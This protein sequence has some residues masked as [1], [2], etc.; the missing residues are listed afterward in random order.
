MTNKEDKV[1]NIKQDMF[2]DRI[3]REYPEAIQVFISNG[4]EDFADSDLIS[5]LGPFLKLKTALK[6][7]GINI[8]LF[9]QLIEEKLSETRGLNMS[10]VHDLKPGQKAPNLLA[11]LPCPLKIPLQE[12]F[13]SFICSSYRQGE[14]EYLIEGNANNQL[15]YYTYVEQFEDIDDVPDIVISP[16]INS[17]F[18]KGFVEKFIDKGYFAD[19]AEYMPG[20]MLKRAGVKDPGGN[21]TMICM[22]LL[23]MVAD[24]DQMGDLPLP[25]SWGDLLHPQYEKKVVIRGQKEFFCETT[26]LTIFK[27]YGL[28]GVEKLG[29][30]VKAGWHPAQMAKMAGSGNVNAPA[31]SVMPYFFTKTIKN[32]GNVKVIWPW[33]GAIISPVSM[34]VKASKMEQLKNAWSFFTGTAAA[35]ICAGAFFPSLHPEVDNKIPEEASFNWLGW[36]FIKS[37]DIGAILNEL[38]QCFLKAYKGYII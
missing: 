20:E 26:L 22:N 19:A 37:R 8:D 33:D 18:Y 13:S 23:V 4:F 17:F 36:E 21:Y 2:I 5:R 28:E 38:N 10:A 25:K 15:S 34:L 29:R 3:L 12:E 1:L 30:S 9:L 11:L 16:G 31:I 35:K 14:L 24:L 32:K 7:R 27:D 6:A